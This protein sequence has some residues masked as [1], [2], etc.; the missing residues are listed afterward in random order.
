MSH[1]TRAEATLPGS[2]TCASQLVPGHLACLTTQEFAAQI[3]KEENGESVSRSPKRQMPYHVCL[4]DPA[5][6]PPACFPQASLDHSAALPTWS[7]C[8]WR[9]NC[10]GS[11]NDLQGSP[12]LGLSRD[13]EEN[14]IRKMQVTEWGR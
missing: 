13:R 4:P 6:H 10:L 5:R 2:L 8:L 3:P 14:S 12:G 1:Y 9:F 7:C 11:Q